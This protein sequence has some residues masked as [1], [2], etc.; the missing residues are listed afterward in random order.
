MRENADQKNSEY[1]HFSTSKRLSGE[2]LCFHTPISSQTISLTFL[3]IAL[4]IRNVAL[5]E[6]ISGCDVHKHSGSGFYPFILVPVSMKL[7]VSRCRLRIMFQQ[8]H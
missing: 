3:K 2:P 8:V 1:G 6:I 7:P 5:S 4:D